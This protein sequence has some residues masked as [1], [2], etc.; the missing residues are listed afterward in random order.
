MPTLDESIMRERYSTHTFNSSSVVRMKEISNPS[1]DMLMDDVEDE[2]DDW[3][4][5]QQ[6]Q[7]PVL[8]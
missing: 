1:S 4:I 2:T 5:S 3:P 7:Q 8:Y 6:Q